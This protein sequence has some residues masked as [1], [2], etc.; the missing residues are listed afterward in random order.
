MIRVPLGNFNRHVATRP[1][2][3]GG[4]LRPALLRI[5]GGI[6]ELDDRHPAYLAALKKYAPLRATGNQTLRPPRPCGCGKPTPAVPPAA[7]KP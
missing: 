4:E 3:Y 7:A 2:G 5:S 6:V 1:D